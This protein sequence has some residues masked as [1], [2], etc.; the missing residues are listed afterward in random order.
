MR[1]LHSR[2]EAT[3]IWLRRLGWAALALAT[4]AAAV[5]PDLVTLPKPE[6][7]LVLKRA[8]YIAADSPAREVALPHAIHSHFGPGPS[9]NPRYLIEFDLPSVPDG[10]LYVY[11]PTV[12]RRL[13]VAFNGES[14]L[15]LESGSLLTGSSVAGPVMARVPNRGIVPGRQQLMV[16]VELGPFVIPAYLSPIYFGT[17]AALAGPYNLGNFVDVQLKA[18]ALAAHLVLGL[19]LIYAY[20]LRPKDTL[21]TWLG[22]LNVVS[23]F[24]ALGVQFG[25]VPALQKF[26]PLVNVLI[27][28]LGFLF[29]GFVLAV[30]G[31]RPP[32]ALRYAAIAAPI[33]LLP[34]LL[35]GSVAVRS[36]A[37]VGNVVVL[38]AAYLVSAGLLTWGAVWRRNSDARLIL[39]PVV[40]IA[41]Y[42]ARDTYVVVTAPDHGFNLLVA[43]PR[44]LLLALVLVMLMR[45]MAMSLDGL[46]S[47]NE[48][49]NVKLAE[50]EAELA[51]L[52]RQERAEATRLTREQE[53]Q[54]LTH[55]LHDGLSGHLVSIIALS[56]RT[57]DRPTE[58]AAREALNDLRLVIYS[59]DLGDRE[60]PLALANFRER[61]IP[62]LHRL[63]V[64][65]DWS[66]AGLPE[67]SGVTP[68]NALAV[69][70][71]LQEAITNALKH[72]PARKITI[73]GAVAANGMA[74]ITI[75]ND[76][77]AFVENNGGHGLANMRRR[78]QQ[79][80][81][82]L[83]IE[84]MDHG[85]KVT[86]LVPPCLPDFED[87]PAA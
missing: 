34:V 75:E 73:R 55:D 11:I 63:G 7:A 76:G 16:V 38:I 5:V 60:L 59:L 20:F 4:L 82:K 22:A 23:L 77:R 37:T 31:F 54:R 65:L 24:I 42:S 52:H 49:L 66:I 2:G 3:S 35:T 68:G 58:Q 10:N 15:E 57:G 30:L 53:R 26:L 85:S 39:G 79:L 32:K 81:G 72:G 40:L 14:I 19:A 9:T 70:R 36:I 8:T 56:E 83:S 29:V 62:Q 78:A 87:E 64:E 41:W 33:V 74:A 17:E 6:G 86:L 45:H 67:V 84:A 46:D 27:P 80:H 1:P 50:R 51:A 61:L 13:A 69:L 28:T 43:Y 44:P 47:A 21:F 71:I 25:W 48:T 12:N 18:M